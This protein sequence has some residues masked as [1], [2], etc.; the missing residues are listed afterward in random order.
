MIAAFLVSPSQGFACQVPQGYKQMSQ[1]EQKKWDEGNPCARS[2]DIGKYTE[3]Q[4]KCM[5]GKPGYTREVV[6]GYNSDGS[7][8]RAYIAPSEE[9]KLLWL[10]ECNHEAYI[11]S[12]LKITG[13]N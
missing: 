4:A 5:D 12:E 7:E 8:I 10:E 11:N 6:K 13:S 2:N 3:L 1:L 9:Q